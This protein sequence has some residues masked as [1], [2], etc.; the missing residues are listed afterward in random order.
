MDIVDRAV[1]RIDDPAER[2]PPLTKGRQAFGGSLRRIFF[3]QEVVIWKGFMNS[4]T[5]GFLR[6]QVCFSHQIF[7][8]FFFGAKAVL[9]VEQDLAPA[10]GGFETDRKKVG[11][12]WAGGAGEG[13]YIV[14]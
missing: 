6:R 10:L 5:D 12:Q 2:R 11:H 1:Q 14:N 4:L 7:P 13:A 9:P 3:A 8:R